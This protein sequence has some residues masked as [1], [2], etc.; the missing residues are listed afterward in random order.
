LLFLIL[1][2]RTRLWGIVWAVLFGLLTLATWPQAIRQI[3]T[4][5]GFPRPL[6]IDYSLL[7]WAAVPWLW[8]HPQWF[9]WRTWRDQLRS[10]RDR[11]GAMLAG[12]WR[13]PR[14][15]SAAFDATLREAKAFLGLA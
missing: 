6:R 3:E 5:L 11:I 10:G 2:P 7:L 12:W 9:E 14:R 13:S 1:P 15:I 8:A 4:V